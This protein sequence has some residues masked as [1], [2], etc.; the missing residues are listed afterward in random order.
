MD[1]WEF[2]DN[3]RKHWQSDPPTP[4]YGTFNLFSA[5]EY[6]SLYCA[7]SLLLLLSVMF[8][9]YDGMFNNITELLSEISQVVSF[10]DT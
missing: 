1:F 5:E 2:T 7:N 8:S 9:Y 4:L 6:I 3:V 10:S